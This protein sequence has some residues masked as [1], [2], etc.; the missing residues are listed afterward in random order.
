[1]GGVATFVSNEVK[2]QALKVTE[3]EGEDEFLVT[4]LGHVVP[5]VNVINV[6][7]GIESRMTKLEVTENWVRIKK[8]IVKI[9]EMGRGAGTDW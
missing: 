6:Y 1:M 9:K 5:A 7:G 4:R 2:A 3:G 8:E